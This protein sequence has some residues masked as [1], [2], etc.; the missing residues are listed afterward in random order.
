[1]FQTAFISGAI[2]PLQTQ[3]DEFDDFADCQSAAAAAAETSAP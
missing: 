1:M 2:F 3:A